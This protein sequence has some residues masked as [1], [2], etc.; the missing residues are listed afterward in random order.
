LSDHDPGVPEAL[1]RVVLLLGRR[2]GAE[3]V[4]R[5]WLFPPLRQGRRESGLVAA[6]CFVGEDGGRNRRRVVTASYRAEMSGGGLT[7]NPLLR[8]EGMAP[9]E[10]L[11]RVVHGVRI[12][13][14]LELGEPREV[15]LGGSVEAMDEFMTEFEGL[16]PEEPDVPEPAD[17][18]GPPDVPGPRAVPGPPDPSDTEAS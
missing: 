10:V 7:V 11:H 4:D 12:R 16:L 1:P 17:V 8:E 2:L 18:P 13:S 15:D 5:L 9:A 14:G 6:S 3:S